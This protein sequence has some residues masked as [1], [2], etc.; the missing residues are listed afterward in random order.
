[1]KKSILL[2]FAI[3]AIL[4]LQAQ[5]VKKH[6]VDIGAGFGLDYGGIGFKFA[7]SPI[8]YLSIFTG[9]GYAIAGP[10][11]NVGLVYNI[12]PKTTKYF[13]RPNIRTMYGYNTAIMVIGVSGHN[14]VYY[15]PSFGLGNEFR[16]GRNKRTGID[17]DINFPI[18]DPQV[19][20]DVDEINATHTLTTKLNYP[21]PIQISLGFHLE[22]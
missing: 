3:S 7:Y 4:N 5:D 20:D 12:L 22:F 15:G 1:M 9:L 21:L 17:L 13:Y 11:Y 6:H 2:V 14:K 19:K 8:P 18:R 10:G 16:F